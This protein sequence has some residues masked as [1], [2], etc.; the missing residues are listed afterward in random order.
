MYKILGGHS[1]QEKMAHVHM[2]VLLM[3][4]SRSEPFF[5][6]IYSFPYKRWKIAKNFFTNEKSVPELVQKHVYFF[7]NYL[8][9][10]LN[11]LKRVSL[12]ISKSLKCID[13][14]VFHLYGRILYAEFFFYKL[15]ICINAGKKG[16]LKNIL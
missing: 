10:L 13:M 12:N 14:E 6:L 3:Y 16:V 9:T 11:Q 4:F 5:W 1:L 7:K 8:I 2:E 15:K